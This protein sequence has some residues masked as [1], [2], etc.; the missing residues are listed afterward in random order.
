[1]IARNENDNLGGIKVDSE[2]INIYVE[3]DVLMTD[4]LFYKSSLVKALKELV[5]KTDL[6]HIYVVGQNNKREIDSKILVNFLDVLPDA[7]HTKNEVLISK[8][9]EKLYQWDYEFRKEIL[10]CEGNIRGTQDYNKIYAT[11][12][13]FKQES[14]M[15]KYIHI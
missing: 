14:D 4:I 1:M 15:R 9:V 8:D 10:Y 7:P 11:D 2:N 12:V 3:E 6:V 13:F 5:K